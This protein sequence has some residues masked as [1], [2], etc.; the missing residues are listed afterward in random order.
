MKK[1][2]L[3]KGRTSDKRKRKFFASG[4]FLAVDVPGHGLRWNIGGSQ[5]V[6]LCCCFSC[7]VEELCP[8][9][10]NPMDCMQHARLPCPSLPPRVCSQIHVHWVGDAIQPSHPLSPP[11]PPALNPSQPQGLFQ[12][13][14]S[15]NQMA[16]ELGVS[17]SA[18]IFPMTIQ[19]WFLLGWTH[20][21]SL[22]SKQSGCVAVVVHSVSCVWLFVTPWIVVH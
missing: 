3:N 22:Q 14:G 6:R 11:S 18:S 17:A 20:L 1:V 15:S 4:S 19:G 9:L 7:S 21:I 8:A 16:K 2:D 12:W 10:C 5:A 13:V